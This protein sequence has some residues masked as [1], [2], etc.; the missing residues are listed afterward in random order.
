MSGSKDLTAPPVYDSTRARAS[1]EQ[2]EAM[3]GR[4]MVIGATHLRLLCPAM[5]I[6]WMRRSIGRVNGKEMFERE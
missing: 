3:S 1:R 5:G 2:I 6:D 4:L